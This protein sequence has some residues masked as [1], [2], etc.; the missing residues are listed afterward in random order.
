MEYEMNE[1][2]MPENVENV[3]Q[4]GESVENGE[5][6]EAET[7][8]PVVS[9]GDKMNIKVEWT[10]D[11]PVCKGRRTVFFMDGWKAECY[12]CFTKFDITRGTKGFKKGIVTEVG[13]G[14]VG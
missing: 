14:V 4:T 7:K 1:A 10:A 2:E 13:S 11:C 5:T 3:E 12:N 9:V 6:V 8:T